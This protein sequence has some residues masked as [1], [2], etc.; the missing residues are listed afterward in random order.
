MAQRFCGAQT[1]ASCNET[2]PKAATPD[3]SKEGGGGGSVVLA[4]AFSAVGIGLLEV[5]VAFGLTVLTM[6][7][8]VGQVSG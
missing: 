3:T 7:Y 1:T 2:G 8:A 6:A 5:S 4:A